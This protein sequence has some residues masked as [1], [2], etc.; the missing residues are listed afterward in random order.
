MRFKSSLA[1]AAAGLVIAAVPAAAAG[2]KISLGDDYY[3]PGIKTVSKGTRVVWV[4]NGRSAHT[5]TTAGWSSTV[6]RGRALG[7]RL[8][9]R[10]HGGTFA[11]RLL[12]TDRPLWASARP[13]QGPGRQSQPTRRSWC[14]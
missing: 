3:N 4:N 13:R 7:E 2:N 5:V 9:E 14:P 1:L 8:A 11:W 6:G 10:L 12:G